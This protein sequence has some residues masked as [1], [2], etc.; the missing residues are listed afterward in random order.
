MHICFVITTPFALNAFVTPVIRALVERGWKVTVMVNTDAGPVSDGLLATVQVIPLDI[1]RQISLRR[2]ITALWVLLKTFHT[3]QFDIVHSI[4]P[5]AGLLAMTAS[6]LAGIKL[7]V[8]T[9]TGQVWATRRG[10][11][12]YLLRGLDQWLARCAN[13]LLVDS[14]SQ[15]DFLVDQGITR[16]QRLHVLGQGS[17]SGV[18]TARF[19]PNAAW[20]QDIRNA[21][22]IPCDASVL[23]YVGRMHVEKGL[24]ELAQ[25]FSRVAS[26]FP[27][28][29]LLLVGPDEGALGLVSTILEPCVKRVRMVGLTSCPEKYMA[30]ADI[31]C[32]PSYREGFGLS[33][34][35]AASMGLPCVASR[36][37]GV[38][39]AVVDG[40]T[41]FLVPVRD[42]AGFAEAAEKLLSQPALAQTMGAAARHRVIAEFSQEVLVQ[43]WL[44]F[45]D[46]RLAELKPLH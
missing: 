39:D 37:Y 25:S 41:G 43:A 45:Y 21:L 2:D 17:I 6:R 11:M 3:C 12:R 40:Q 20:R 30:V 22:G 34:V 15:R 44:Q 4:T 23:L 16:L 7:R 9:F 35:E 18:D 14:F 27:K 42:S 31:F 13:A 5:K 26:R 38:T 19:S 29:Y 36:I 10:S 1:A 46:S 33:L 8:H 24:V 28:A 32:L